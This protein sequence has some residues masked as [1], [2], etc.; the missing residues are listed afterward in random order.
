M[1]GAATPADPAELA[2]ILGIPRQGGAQPTNER[3]GKPPFSLLALPVGISP[4]P[5][6]AR[7]PR[8]R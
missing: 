4:R 2:L 3:P 6:P 1:L 7:L 5:A 8:L